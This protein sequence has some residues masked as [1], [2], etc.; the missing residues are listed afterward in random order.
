MP[1]DVNWENG[2]A[3]GTAKARQENRA[4]EDRKWLERTVADLKAELEK[5]PADQQEQLRRELERENRE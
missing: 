4:A 5:L 1:I 2:K 3:C